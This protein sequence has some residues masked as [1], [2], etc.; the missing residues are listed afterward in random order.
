MKYL[1]DQE[2]D[3]KVKKLRKKRKGKI[4]LINTL[5]K[6]EDRKVFTRISCHTEPN[7]RI[8]LTTIWLQN[9]RYNQLKLIWH[10]PLRELNPHYRREKAFS[11]RLKEKGSNRH[12]WIWTTDSIIINDVLLPTKLQVQNYINWFN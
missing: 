6:K 4:K 7:V 8:E 2:N 10:N 1:Y 5:I 11:Y 9:S 3:Q 12:E